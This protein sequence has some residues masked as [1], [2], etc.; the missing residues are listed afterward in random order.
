MSKCKSSRTPQNTLSV[1][2][3]IVM[4]DPFKLAGGRALFFSQ[5]LFFDSSQP[6]L[7]L[8]NCTNKHGR[9]MSKWA[10]GNRQVKCSSSHLLHSSH[11]L[12]DSQWLQ[13]SLSVV[14]LPLLEIILHLFQVCLCYL[15][16]YT[17]YYQ[18]LLTEL[19]AEWPLDLLTL[20]PVGLFCKRGQHL[21]TSWQRFLLSKFQ[22]F[23]LWR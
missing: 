10:P 11:R 14:V 15:T 23:S 16:L 22:L 7:A 2:I 8:F 4:H 3:C 18:S 12:T 19:L 5:A 13:C 20:L 6:L 1:C 17:K 21:T 9:V